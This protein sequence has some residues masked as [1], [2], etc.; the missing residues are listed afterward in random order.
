MNHCALCL[1]FDE[2]REGADLLGGGVPLCAE[3]AASCR[4]RARKPAPPQIIGSPSYEDESFRLAMAGKSMSL[5]D[6]ARPANV[7]LQRG[8]G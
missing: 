8:E 4:E 1:C 7:T 6:V 3:H 5:A 2:H